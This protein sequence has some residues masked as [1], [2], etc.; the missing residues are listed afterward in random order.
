MTRFSRYLINN[1][2]R[3]A[4]FQFIIGNKLPSGLPISTPFTF[5]FIGTKIVLCLDKNNWWNPLGGHMEK[6][7]IYQDTLYR[8]SQEEAGIFISKASI[9][10]IG[11]I[12]NINTRNSK[13]SEYQPEN[14]LPITTSF[15]TSIDSKWKPLETTKRGLFSFKE[16]LKLMSVRN[17]NH[18]MLE[19]LDFVIKSYE[20]CNY[21]VAF[22]YYPNKLFVNVPITQVFTFC[23]NL[24]GDFCIVKDQDESF[25]SLPGGGCELGE[26]PE[27]CIKR[28]LLEE[29]Q[30]T[31]KNIKLLG[32]ILVELSQEG[33]IVSK[34]Q[35]LRY[36]ADVD[37]QDSFIPNK[38]GFE[39]IERIFVPFTELKNKVFLL[40]NLT[41]ERI[42]NQVLSLQNK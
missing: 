26:S 18:Q 8:E 14:I 41:A 11:Y 37:T 33:K 12:K 17:D 28:E 24:V 19:I 25:Y 23:K 27:A 40:Q 30:V 21:Q 6:D 34:S 3:E 29:A 5:P 7:E 15:V 1:D 10:I 2:E 32:S 13:S 31:C 42:L 39:T 36:L 22:T 20:Q 38:N 35:H 4:S 16:A 9:K